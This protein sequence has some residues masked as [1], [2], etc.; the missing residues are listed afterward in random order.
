MN[1][2]PFRFFIGEEKRGDALKFVAQLKT[3]DIFKKARMDVY[4]PR[5]DTSRVIVCLG[6][7]HTILRGKITK[8]GAK[9]I[10]KVQARLFSYYRYF[11]QKWEVASFGAEGVIAREKGSAYKYHD[12]LLR[13]HLEDREEKELE[14]AD[15]AVSIETVERILKRLAVEWWRKMKLFGQDLEHGEQEI[16]PFAAVVNGL[17]LYNYVA[18]H[19]LFYPIEGEGAYKKVSDGV[20]ASEAEMIKMRQ[21]D[22]H[23][24]AA[25]EKQGKG[26]T[27]EEYDAM[28]KYNRLSQDFNRAITSTYRE[29]ASLALALEKFEEEAA[30]AARMSGVGVG[31]GEKEGAASLRYA[32]EATST[33]SALGEEATSATASVLVFTMGIGHRSNYMRLVPR[34]LKYKDAAFVLITPPELWW[35]KHVVGIVV[36]LLIVVG[37]AGVAGWYFWW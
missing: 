4:V 19:V 13:E 34:Y 6:Q 25:L 37:L 7:K 10:A 5:A 17:R 23:L 21:T 1:I 33:G 29:E 26:L 30:G 24:K 32:L 11:N 27:Q 15:E 35:W 22:F 36:K 20:R 9:H 31:E 16:A 2:Y 14:A 8:W 18:E 28:I 3:T 12:D